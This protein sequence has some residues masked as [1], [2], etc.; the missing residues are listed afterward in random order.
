MKS[1][2][3]F[4]VVSAVFLWAFNAF[5]PGA[6]AATSVRIA[7]MASANT[8]KGAKYVYGREGGYSR[9][10]DCSGLIK[11]AYKQRGKTLPRTAQEQYNKSKKVAVKDR[12]LGDLIFI[13]DA[14]GHVYH[15][16]IFTGVRNGKGY[17][18]NANSGSYR[19]RKVVEAP[20]SE[21]TAGSPTAVYGRY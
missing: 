7:A 11:W 1:T 9:G 13:R 20:I 14:R 10:Y 12:K 2:S 3:K 8:Q 6:E 19:G 5:S 16:G 17:M 21:Y 4:I 15:V 18:L